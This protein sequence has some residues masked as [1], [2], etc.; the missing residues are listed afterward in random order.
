MKDVEY[1][2]LEQAIDVS[3]DAMKL[4]KLD[5]QKQK[6]LR[7]RSER[8]SAGIRSNFQLPKHR[9]CHHITI[10]ESCS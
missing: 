4:S 2:D 5:M 1:A 3:C 9:S 7:L 8:D 6:V 10:A